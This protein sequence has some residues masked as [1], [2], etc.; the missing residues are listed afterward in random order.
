M[1]I[2]IMHSFASSWLPSTRT[3]FLQDH[4]DLETP[5]WGLATTEVCC[6]TF[7]PHVLISF[8]TRVTFTCTGWSFSYLHKEFLNPRPTRPAPSSPRFM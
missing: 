3:Y 4:W 2:D 6:Y 7:V 5:I 1:T 8:L